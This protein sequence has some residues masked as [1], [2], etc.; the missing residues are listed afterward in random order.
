MNFFSLSGKWEWSPKV[1]IFFVTT[2]PITCGCLLLWIAYTDRF[3]AL[4]ELLKKRL[5]AQKRAIPSVEK[6]IELGEKPSREPAQAPKP[7]PELIASSSS[8]NRDIE[9]QAGAERTY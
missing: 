4:K 8:S 3:K 1:W 5:L 2:V 7:Q 6:A 9:A